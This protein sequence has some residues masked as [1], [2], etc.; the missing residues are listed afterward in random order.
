MIVNTN[1]YRALYGNNPLEAWVQQSTSSKAQ[2][3]QRNVAVIG[4]N[5]DHVENVKFYPSPDSTTYSPKKIDKKLENQLRSYQ[6]TH[7]ANIM[8]HQQAEMFSREFNVLQY[9]TFALNQMN[10]ANK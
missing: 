5:V 3:Q 4:R 10:F 2:Q 6:I 7:P 8:D 9:R 1:K